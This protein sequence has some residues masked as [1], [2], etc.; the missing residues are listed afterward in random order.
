MEQKK[1][2]GERIQKSRKAKGLSQTELAQSIDKTLR[3]IQKYESGEIEVSIS[4]INQI[5][6][7]LD[8]SPAYLVGYDKGKIRLDTLADILA[9][10]FELDNIAG[11]NFDIVSKHAGRD[12]VFE[13]TIVF[14]G[15]DQSA[16]L[17]VT[18]C[19]ALEQ[20]QLRRLER[21]TYFKTNAGVKMWEDLSLADFSSIPLTQKVYEELDPTEYLRRRNALFKVDAE[22]ASDQ[23][24]DN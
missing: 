14:K 1:A 8:V 5:S 23:N 10:I 21:E 6:K 17:N 18:I 15:D 13:S 24:S 3:T 19:Q 4:T 20:F 12:G 11:I 2:I 16:P 9:Y 22:K 7:I